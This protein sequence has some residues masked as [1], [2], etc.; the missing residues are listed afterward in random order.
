MPDP[1][2]TTGLSL[3]RPHGMMHDTNTARFD[4]GD[5]ARGIMSMYT[6][7]GVFASQVGTPG[8]DTTVAEQFGTPGTE[9]LG[10]FFPGSGTGN[11]NGVPGEFPTAFADTRNNLIKGVDF[12]VFQIATGTTPGTGDGQLYQPEF[13]GAFVDI[14]SYLLVANTLNNRIE[15]YEISI[16]ALTFKSSF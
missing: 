5:S 11:I 9:G 7:T 13:G 1:S 15:V 8:T 16:L 2:D 3:V 14:Q 10:L 4:V 6:T 12:E